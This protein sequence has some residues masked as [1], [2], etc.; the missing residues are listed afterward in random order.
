MIL[1][2]RSQDVLVAGSWNVVQYALL[3]IFVAVILSVYE[4][5]NGG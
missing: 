2:Q 5:Y 3:L 1:N 4:I